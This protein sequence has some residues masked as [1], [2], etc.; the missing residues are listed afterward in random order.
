MSIPFS[1]LEAEAMSLPIE[2]RALLLDRLLASLGSDPEIEAA[3]A[4]EAQRRDE[5]VESGQVVPIALDDVLAR[6]RAKAR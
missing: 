3:W 6:L 2:A 5:E 1:E 4:A